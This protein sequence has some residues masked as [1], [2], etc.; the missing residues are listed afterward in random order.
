MLIGLRFSNFHSFRDEQEL[1]L[2]AAPFTDKPDIPREADVEQFRTRLLPA[3]AIYGANA[4]GKTNVLR[5]ISF[6]AEAVLLSHS[7]WKPDGPIPYEPFLFADNDAPSLFEIEF[8]TEATRYHYGF[9]VNK[10][11]VLEEWLHAYPK[12]HKQTWFHRREGVPIS[13]ST[14]LV[15]ENKTIE[16]LTRKNSLFSFCCCPEQPRK[17]FTRVPLDYS[18]ALYYGRPS[19]VRS[20]YSST[21]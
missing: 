1:S 8:L 9:R 16:N 17:T 18:V 2:V 4:S 3:C 5:A 12:G 6:I 19:S 13:F 15:G 11:A 10:V 14:K 20:S 7:Q 21:V